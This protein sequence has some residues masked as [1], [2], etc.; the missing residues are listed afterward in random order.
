MGLRL[1]SYV[2]VIVM[3]LLLV[4][5]AY[6][7]DPLLPLPGTPI[8]VDM[9]LTSALPEELADTLNGLQNKTCYNFFG[10]TACVGE[11]PD[12]PGQTV[13][14]L[15]AGSQPIAVEESAVRLR[16]HFPPKGQKYRLI[17]HGGI[18]GGFYQPFVVGAPEMQP[19]DSLAAAGSCATNTNIFQPYLTQGY[20]VVKPGDTFLTLAGDEARAQQLYDYNRERLRLSAPSDLKPGQ[21]LLKPDTWAPTEATVFGI[22]YPGYIFAGGTKY[23]FSPERPC[24]Y[25]SPEALKLRD[26]VV[27]QM[28][29]APLPASIVD[30]RKKFLPAKARADAKIFSG[31]WN[32]GSGFSWYGDPWIARHLQ[33][34]YRVAQGDMETFFLVAGLLGDWPGTMKVEADGRYLERAES[35]VLIYRTSSDPPDM[36]AGPAIA[37]DAFLKDPRVTYGAVRAAYKSEIPYDDLKKV[38]SAQFWE[39]NKIAAKLASQ[40]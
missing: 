32:E 14:A 8:P 15:V 9:V 27:A 16:Y 36:Y 39:F 6:S 22:P 20:I 13:L 26:A 4:A 24:I 17:T 1:T 18:A 7:A 29:L 30:Y 10:R 35:D 2:M 21:L 3:W 12:V 38:Q 37:I 34:M 19:G 23:R 28:K 40:Q 25:L 11:V 5:P 31:D 33:Q